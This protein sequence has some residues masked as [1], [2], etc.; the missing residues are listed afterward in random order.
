MTKAQ[1]IILFALLLTVSPLA[2]AAVS[3]LSVAIIPPVQFPSSKFSITGARIS[4]LW[5]YHQDVY[6]IDVG[7]IGN[8]TAQDFTG[9]GV[10]GVFNYT[11]GTT[12]VLGLQLAGIGNF[13]TN[14]TRVFGVQAAGIIN[15]NTASA[16]VTGVQVALANLAAHTD[17]YGVQ[18]GLYNKAKV[19]YGF[20]IGVINSAANLYGLQIGLLNFHDKGIFVVSPI[21]NVGF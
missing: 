15:S 18:I 10:S 1:R 21:L 14:K 17:I 11:K 20:Q 9:I 7:A 5:G 2:Q 13:N 19:V 12:T 4:A 16:S 3:P 6:G 8:I